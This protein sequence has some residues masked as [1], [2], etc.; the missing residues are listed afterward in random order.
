MI[1][2]HLPDRLSQRREPLLVGPLDD[3]R[4]GLRGRNPPSTVR[5]Q[6]VRIR[7]LSRRTSSSIAPRGSRLKSSRM[8]WW[9][10]M[11]R[12]E[13]QALRMQVEEERRNTLKR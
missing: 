7:R 8:R 11:Q 3:N 4:I 13:R 6:P 2:L 12:R 10:R 9:R 5:R 1:E